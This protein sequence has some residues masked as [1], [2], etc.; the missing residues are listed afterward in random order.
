MAETELPAVAKTVYLDCKK[1]GAE[2][3]FVVLAHTSSTSAKVKCE[4]CGSQK[5]YKLKAEKKTASGAPKKP[6]VARVSKADEHRN[7]YEKLLAESDAA[8]AKYNMKTS[9]ANKQKLE[10]PKFG[11]GVIRLSLADKIEVVFP[12]EVRSLVHN[13]A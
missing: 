6:R 12:D 2:R 3:Y 8:P 13:R 10:H 1:C 7:E 4:V 9:F 11:L 5:T